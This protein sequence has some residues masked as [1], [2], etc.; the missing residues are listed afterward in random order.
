MTNRRLFLASG[1]S[2]LS[3]ATIGGHAAF[4]QAAASNR[5]FVMIIL[6]GAMD[7]L[8]AVVPYADPNYRSLRGAIALSEPGT[9]DGVLDLGNGFG[10]HP[11]LKG[12]HGLYQNKQ[13]AFMH[14]ASSPYRDRSHFDGQDVLE[15]GAS[16][17]YGAQDGWLNRA[18]GLLP[19]ASSNEGV[20]IGRTLPLVLRGPAK[21]SSWAPPLAPESDA[22]T[23]MRLM[24]LYQGDSLL[25]PAL[26]MAI[27]TDA[28][29]DA[30]T[31]AMGNQR[32]RNMGFVP[33]AS[34]AARILTAPGGPAA[35]VIALDGWDTHAGQGSARGAL[36][37]RFAQLD[38][39]VM[40]LK[41][42][43]GSQWA[44]TTVIIATEFGRT[45]RVNGTNGT[46]HGTGG[47]AFVLGGGLSGRVAGGRMLGD[48]PGLGRLYQDRDLI[49][50]N[51]LRDL[52]A[53]GLVNAW[54][55]DR[56]AIAE[57]VFK[58]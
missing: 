24:D 44:N 55:L 13:M 37:N 12:L 51:D 36:A 20:A 11:E 42:G 35:G 28:I 43:M 17:L 54:G 6:R 49:P 4:A 39:A 23:L 50:A 2:G 34:A 40:A 5:K 47:A 30:S 9:S 7:G 19:R 58:A 15:S 21:A 33:L 52:F 8:S 26:S 29:A 16:R 32:G 27:E 18:I 48:W 25:G 56:A 14:A 31:M 3:L 41:T 22:D 10:L 38:Q 1:L 46:D 45:A 53:D 57:R